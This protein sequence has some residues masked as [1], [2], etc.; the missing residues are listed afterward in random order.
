MSI[1]VTGGAGTRGSH[2]VDTALPTAGEIVMVR[3]FDVAGGRSRGS[4]RR[5]CPL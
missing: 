5:R 2:V 1:L 3:D 4:T